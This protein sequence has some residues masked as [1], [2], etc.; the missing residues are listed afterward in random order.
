[1]MYKVLF[2]IK[3]WEMDSLWELGGSCWRL[4][5]PSFY[6]THTEKEI[7]QITKEI[8]ENYEKSL[9]NFKPLGLVLSEFS[10]MESPDLYL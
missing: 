6:Y 7:Q 8:I 9:T 1:M 2:K 10:V 3:L 5:P 4:F